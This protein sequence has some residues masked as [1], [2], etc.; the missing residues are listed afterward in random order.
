MFY[1]FL[2]LV[3]KIPKWEKINYNI[4]ITTNQKVIFMQQIDPTKTNQTIN[5]INAD[6]TIRFAEVS[7]YGKLFWYLSFTLIIPLILHIVFT[8]SFRRS[9]VQINETASGI[10][11]QLQK[12]RD[13]LIKLVDATKSG[14]KY[15]RETLLAVTKLRNY[16]QADR[17]QNMRLLDKIAPNILAVAENYPNL[18]AEALIQDLMDQAAYIEKEIAAARRLYNSNVTIFNQKVFA[19]P[20]NVIAAKAKY[21]TYEMFLATSEARSDISLQLN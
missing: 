7:F 18:K 3:I 19:W 11:V 8:N 5:P 9:M 15:E 6:N 17:Q 1:L 21:H 12:R 14:M 2:F 10:D 20:T 13:T 4:I 16:N